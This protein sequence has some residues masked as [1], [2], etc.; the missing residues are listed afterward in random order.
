MALT[1]QQ[2]V[3]LKHQLQARYEELR[4]E[5]RRELLKS[6]SESYA[7]LAGQVHDHAEESIANLL[8]DVELAVIDQHITSLREI[9]TA[10]KRL[11][12]GSYGVCIG[13]GDEIPLARLETHPTASRCLSC[14]QALEG[15]DAHA[16]PSL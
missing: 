5:I 2:Q 13:C 10:I 3:N 1:E 16:I 7:E 14:Q 9:E 15:V 6:D 4:D 8:V 11:N 12:A